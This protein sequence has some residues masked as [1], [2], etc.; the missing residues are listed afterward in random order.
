MV[1]EVSGLFLGESQGAP[2]SLLSGGAV[3]GGV[4]E[5]EEWSGMASHSLK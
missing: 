2:F 1:A 5:G 4:G 3:L